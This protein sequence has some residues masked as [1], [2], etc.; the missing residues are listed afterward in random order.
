MYILKGK[1]EISKPTKKEIKNELI[2]LQNNETDFVILNK[3]DDYIQ[4]TLISNYKLPGFYVELHLIGNS[5]KY[6]R[7]NINYTDALNLF[8]DFLSD[9][10]N[11]NNYKPFTNTTT[12]KKNKKNSKKFYY[13]VGIISLVFLGTATFSSIMSK[14]PWYAGFPIAIVMTFYFTAVIYL[15]TWLYNEFI[16]NKIKK[17]SRKIDMPCYLTYDLLNEGYNIN[18]IDKNKKSTKKL[19]YLRFILTLLVVLSI[20]LNML[21]LGVLGLFAFLIY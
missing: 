3:D 15:E 8:I 1:T 20:I 6:K 11:L 14:D 18:I 7:N 9:K 16:P 4:T 13:T 19:I 21:A 12:N 10:N 5:Y 17:I 2:N